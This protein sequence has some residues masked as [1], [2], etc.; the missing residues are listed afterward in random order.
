MKKHLAITL[1]LVLG[2]ALGLAAASTGS[3]A[4]TGFATAIEPVGTAFVNLVRMVVV[5]VVA[6]T[7]FTGVVKLGDPRRLGRLGAVTLGFFWV[8]ILIG[9][10]VG[11]STMALM[12]PFAPETT[13]PALS[14]RPAERLPGTVDFLLSLIPTNVVDVAARGALLPLVVFSVLFGAAATTLPDDA[15]GRLLGLAEAVTAAM[16]QLVHW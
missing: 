3:A 8:T 4:L 9:I 6:S 1:G 7:V 5:P 16:I 10:V 14:E 2:L 12:L 15:R 13:P 11:M